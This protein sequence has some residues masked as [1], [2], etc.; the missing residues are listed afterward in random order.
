M[1]IPFPSSIKKW[2]S[3]LLLLLV[4]GCSPSAD[5]DEQSLPSPADSTS[6]ETQNPEEPTLLEDKIVF[7][8][9]V[10]PGLGKVYNLHNQTLINTLHGQYSWPGENS[11]LEFFPG[12]SSLESFSATHQNFYYPLVHKF[13]SV[14]KVKELRFGNATKIR[15]TWMKRTDDN[16]LQARFKLYRNQDHKW[17]AYGNPGSFTFPGDGFLAGGGHIPD[18]KGMVQLVL[19]T[20]VKLTYK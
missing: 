10:N 15:L 17:M 12:D 3:L 20:L 14:Q 5:Q 1:S 7:F 19:S 16:R 9:L 6:I 13:F 8:E 2:T 18:E 4:W 11:D